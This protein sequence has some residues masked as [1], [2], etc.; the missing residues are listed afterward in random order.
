MGERILVF[1]N[2]EEQKRIESIIERIEH[3]KTR[4]GSTSYCKCSIESSPS[5]RKKFDSDAAVIIVLVIVF[6]Y[7]LKDKANPIEHF[8]YTVNEEKELSFVV[9]KNNDVAIFMLTEEIERIKLL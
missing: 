5:F 7:G 3:I 1:G 4:H 9:V 8:I 6:L 2:I